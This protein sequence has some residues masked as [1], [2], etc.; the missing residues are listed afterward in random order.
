MGAVSGS[1]C[2]NKGK[3]CLV[4]ENESFINAET[5]PYSL[6]YPQRP[7]QHLAHVASE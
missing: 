5:L 2:C 3:F 7:E 6:L 4:F 1:G